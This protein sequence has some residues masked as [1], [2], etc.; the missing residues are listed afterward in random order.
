VA[1]PAFR[2]ESP[3]LRK[4]TWLVNC[5]HTLGARTRKTEES[6]TTYLQLWAFW[7]PGKKS[8]GGEIWGG[9]PG[10]LHE[11]KANSFL[12][13]SSLPL[14]YL[15]IFST[16][17]PPSLSPMSWSKLPSLAVH[18]TVKILYN[19]RVNYEGRRSPLKRSVNVPVMRPYPK[20]R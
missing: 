15:L 10:K 3:P 7:V 5:W 17:I 9:I 12:L 2:V 13:D 18:R 16:S 11:R 14:T 20:G 1:N 6:P 19:E 8:G 4:N